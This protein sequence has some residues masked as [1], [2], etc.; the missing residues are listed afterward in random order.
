MKKI[1]IILCGIAFVS[2]SL[3]SCNKG[4][5][6][7]FNGK[8]S[9]NTDSVSYSIGVN[10]AENL[11]ANG[12]DDINIAALAKAMQDVKDSTTI[13][14]IEQ[15]G[16]ILDAYA[17]KKQMEE[18]SSAK[19]EGQAF[20]A[21]N[22]KNPNVKTTPSGLQYEVIE[23]G[24][25]KS[26]LATDKVKVNYHGTLTDGSVFDSSMGR[27]PVTFVL[28]Q[29]IP[30]WTEGLQLMKEGAKYRFYIPSDLAYGDQGM[31][32]GAIPGGSTLIFDVD[33]LEVN[34][35]EGK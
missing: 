24:T 3:F 2:L 31:G 23:E 12:V 32:G 4:G 9:N 16:S 25:G 33:L 11:K 13:L 35:A 28:N 29:V 6:G 18:A 17:M 7:H 14:T 26:P 22:A 15:A 34:P 30:G 8:L 5:V 21:E 27:E 20:L 1:S 10:F 19:A